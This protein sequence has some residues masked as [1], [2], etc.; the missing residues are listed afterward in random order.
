MPLHSPLGAVR[1]L[2]SAKEGVEHFK[3]QRLTAMANILLV[4][5]LIVSCVGLTGASYE[6]TVAW[7]ASPLTAT[8]MILT[9][10]SLFYHASLG[11]QVVLEDYV[12]HEGI[13]VASLVALKLVSFALAALGVVS[14]LMVAFGS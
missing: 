1:G 13:K 4:L 5:W 8:L 11:V 9:L 7:L 10:I 14:V 6:E 12:H 3:M 2:G